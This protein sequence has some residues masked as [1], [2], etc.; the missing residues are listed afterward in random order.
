MFSISAN[1][2]ITI[3]TKIYNNDFRIFYYSFHANFRI[4]C[5]RILLVF[6]M[7][8][9]FACAPNVRTIE[10]YK[11]N[12]KKITEEIKGEGSNAKVVKRSEYYLNGQ[13]KSEVKITNG[14]SNGKYLAYY[15]NGVI[16]QKGQYKLGKEK[17]KWLYYNNSG[18]IDSIHTY[19]EGLLDGNTEYNVYG[20]LIIKQEYSSGMKDGDFVEFYSDGNKKVTGSYVMNL[21]SKKWTWYNL[22]ESKTR[23]IHFT[24]GV[25]N[26]EFRVWRDGSLYLFGI[27]DQDKKSGTWK[28]HRTKKDLDSLVTYVDGE[29]NGPYQAWYDN[30]I[31]S[32]SG[33]FDN[34]VPNGKWEWFSQKNTLDSTKTFKNGLLNGISTFHYKNGQIKRSVNFVSDILHGEDQSFFASGQ[35]KEKTTYIS[36]EKSGPYELWNA[37]ST[38][39][40]KGAFLNNELHGEIQ[41]WY[42]S[43][44]PASITS[45]NSGIL[46][47]VMQVYSLSKQLKRELFYDRGKEIARFE[48]HDNGRFKRVLILKETKILYE[49][50]W[51]KSGLEE[52]E[53]KYIVGT[54]L[55]S[56]F[57]LSGSLR[58]ECIY[59]NKNKHGMEWWF[60]EDRNPRKINLYLNGDKIINHELS[61]E[62]N[63]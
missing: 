52:T 5:L 42:S 12:Q 62:I 32:V 10:T 60:N 45:Y 16:S 49:R 25:K 27:F 17:G 50:K 15:P 18:Q 31:L 29:I 59:K 33:S 63:E 55:E 56:K 30:G 48:Y 35:M 26:G 14:K 61:Y 11:S 51:N 6:V 22:N 20:K 8:L 47:G 41:R 57:Y 40:E 43:G 37:S 19:S 2:F 9:I 38:Q 1:K 53:E 44:I 54:S 39:E 36:G 7:T 3:F 28:W 4:M 13:I 23:Q 21:P 34:G 24:N 46:D 58:Y